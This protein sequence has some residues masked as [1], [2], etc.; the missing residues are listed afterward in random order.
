[1]NECILAALL[2]G[3]NET[4]NYSFYPSKRKKTHFFAL[5]IIVFCSLKVQDPNMYE[6]KKVIVCIDLKIHTKGAFVR[7]LFSA[8]SPFSM[9]MC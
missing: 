1:M 7:L 4:D 6:T 5:I 3:K 2:G 8:Y 9:W